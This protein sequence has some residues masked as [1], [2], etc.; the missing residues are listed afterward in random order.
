M[1]GHSTVERGVRIRERVFSSWEELFTEESSPRGLRGPAARAWLGVMG[2]PLSPAGLSRSPSL[3]PSADAISML[4]SSKV[5]TAAAGSGPFLEP[6]AWGFATDNF[7][8]GVSH[9][10]FSETRVDGLVVPMTFPAVSEASLTHS[11]SSLCQLALAVAVPLSLSLAAA[12]FASELVE[13]HT[14]TSP[15]V[16]NSPLI[17][18]AGLCGVGTVAQMETSTWPPVPG[19]TVT[20]VPAVCLS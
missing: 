11:V 3:L 5:H 2:G 7:S 19:A 16:W 20:V 4:V 12:F 1:S 6:R 9:I 13:P 18:E 8:R 14:W 10:H 17:V 15:V